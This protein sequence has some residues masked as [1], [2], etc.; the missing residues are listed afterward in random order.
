[1]V[2]T[3]IGFKISEHFL[4]SLKLFSCYLTQYQN[5]ADLVLTT[6][7]FNKTYGFNTQ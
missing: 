6:S 3:S 4:L 2:L 7:W 1:M 5:N